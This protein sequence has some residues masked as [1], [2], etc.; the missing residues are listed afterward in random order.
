MSLFAQILMPLPLQPTFTYAVPREM[1]ERVRPGHRVVVPFGSKKFYTG[2]VTELSNTPP[3][4]NYEVKEIASTL[5]DGPIIRRPQLQLWDWMAEYYLCSPGDVFRAALPAAL[6]VESETF[7]EANPDFETDQA[8][9]S[10]RETIILQFLVH[11][12]G[13]MKVSEIEKATG[14]KNVGATT[15]AMLDK[16]AVIISEK[17]IERYTS[18]KVTYT[19]LTIPRYDNDAL[20]QAF[21]KVKNKSQV[22]QQIALQTLVALS[23]FMQRS[24]ELKEVTQEELMERSE[25][26]RAVLKQ[27]ADKGILEFYRKE[28]NR[29]QYNGLVS[30]ELPVLSPAQDTAL[31]EIHRSWLEKDITLLHGV[32]SSG[33]TEIYIHLIDFALKQNRQAL[34]LVPEIALTTQLT[35]RLPR[36]FGNKVVIYHSKFTDNERVDIYRKVLTS[37]DPMVI[38]G[39]RSSLF[40]PFAQL[41]LVIVDEEHE[42]SYKQQDPAPRYNGRDTA[43]V[44]ARMHG[45]KILLGSATPAVD[46]YYKALSGR[47]GLVSLMERYSGVELPEISIIDTNKARKQNLM[48]GALAQPTVDLI[49]K[50]LGKKRQA[51]VFLNRRGYSPVAVCKQ[52][53][54]TPKCEHCDVTLTY[55]KHINRLVCHYCGAMY[56][57]TVVC[58]NCHEPA[59]ETFGYGTERMTDEVDE[60]LQGATTIRMDLDTTRNKDGYESLITQFSQGKAD[61]LVGTQM[62]TK[63]LDFDR[64]D[65][66]AV[67]NADALVNQPDFRASERAF[68]MMMQVAGRAG[69]RDDRGTVA[70]QTSQPT[71]PLF[72]FVAQHDYSKFYESEIEDRKKF[73]YPPF[74]RV[75]NIYIKHRDRAMIEELAI[76]Y[77]KR[78]RQLF[79]N[80]VFGP[81]EPIV[82]RI[83]SLYIRKLMLKIETQASMKKVKD[84]M[85]QTFIEMHESGMQAAKGAI[86]YYDVDP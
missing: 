58:P 67:V 17:L 83:Q 86:V 43:M 29:F 41:G 63:G 7:I 25:V 65:A 19:R 48:R 4:G 66:V 62:V 72:S 47:Y 8:Q 70:I 32:T 20:R 60:A 1:S 78:L 11:K 61:V 51:I 40:L 36:V 45:A 9:L 85:R 44:L 3:A 38:I 56:P 71:L 73:S 21:D 33:K 64:V 15:A 37:N 14:F 46:T 22:R 27:L 82:G 54:H 31:K 30:G 52:C 68:N 49:K 16:G 84:I 13:R 26:P 18:R 77:G 23:G 55:H 69:R 76:S 34:F 79:G 81:E 24:A 59:I 39:A 35:K 74:T 10:E 2:I 75:I 6:K 53:G 50:A 5:D 57:K 28:I 80:R 12:E 42:S